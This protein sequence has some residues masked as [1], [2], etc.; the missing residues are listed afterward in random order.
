VLCLSTSGCATNGLASIPLPHPG[1]SGGGYTITAELSDALNLPAFAKVRLGGA[2]VGQLESITVRNYTAIAKLQIQEGVRLPK[3]TT[4]ELRSATPLGDVFVAVKPPANAS[5]STPLLRNGD[6][7]PLKDTT[8][9]A[10]VEN[11]LT[12][13]AVLVNGGAVQSLTNLLN[14]AGKAVGENGGGN[15]R[16]LVDN[17]TRLLTTMNS[18]TDQLSTSLTELSTLSDRI[19]AKNQMLDDL[20]GAAAPATDTLADQSSQIADLVV[21]TG[22]TTQM[23]AKFP[24]IGGTDTSGRSMIEDLNTIAGSFNDVVL[25]PKAKLA[26][27]NRLMPPL[28][29]ASP[30]NALS[31]R[32]SIDR[33]I[34]GSIPDIGY[35]GDIG[36]HG[37]KWSTW[38]QL[39][40]SF[41][42]ILFRLQERV[43][44]R[45]PNVPQV[46][47]LPSPTDPGQWVVNGPPPGPT[48]PGDF[49]APP[50]SP[51]SPAPVPAP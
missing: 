46:P 24:S 33:L 40:G 3:G 19:N 50:G 21:Q 8:A 5:S 34:L 20:L 44:G 6:N 7:I 45:G 17:T 10:T 16:G 43:V 30:S 27:L 38:N 31:V 47:V 9:A 26:A 11:L 48:A 12:G 29:K 4:V 39:V 18:R 14:G 32:G 25:D 22:Q 36:L 13:A 35:L 2:D 23:L 41:K 42:Y 15:F 49:V 51:A 37:P 28:I 1:E